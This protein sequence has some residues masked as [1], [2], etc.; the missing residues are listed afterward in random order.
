MGVIW[1]ASKM[2][3]TSPKAGFS[4]CGWYVIIYVATAVI[5]EVAF[6]LLTLV[7]HVDATGAIK[8]G[9]WIVSTALTV[10]VAGRGHYDWGASWLF[11]FV[12]LGA[13]FIIWRRNNQQERALRADVTYPAKKYSPDTELR[14]P[15]Y[16][17]NAEYKWPAHLE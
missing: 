17:D 11:L 9:A 8:P 3:G 6:T 4:A 12:P 1:L 10:Q 5:V 15:Q 14:R 16:S 2:M 7:L 13:L